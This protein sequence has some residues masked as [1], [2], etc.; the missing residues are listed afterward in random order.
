MTIH[1][2]P[3]QC[4]LRLSIL[5]YNCC[6]YFLIP[7]SLLFLMPSSALFNV[8]GAALYM[9]KEDLLHLPLLKSKLNSLLTTC[10]SR[11]PHLHTHFSLTIYIL[12]SLGPIRQTL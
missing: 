4:L 5:D 3:P 11:A 8:E 7:L 2:T 10:C 9:E 1:Q 6:M 12:S